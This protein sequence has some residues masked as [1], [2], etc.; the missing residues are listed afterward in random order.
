MLFFFLNGT[1]D[2][3]V[4]EKSGCISHAVYA[5][6]HWAMSVL[7]CSFPEAGAGWEISV[8]HWP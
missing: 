3:E 4:K 8:Q 7:H 1:W 6:G 5:P 2:H